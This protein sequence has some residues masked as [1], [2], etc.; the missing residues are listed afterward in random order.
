MDETDSPQTPVELLIILA[1]LADER[2]PIQ[3]I[4]PKF[5]GRFN[6][7]VDYV[8]DLAKFEQEFSDDIAVL[9]FAI[10]Q[11]GFPANL[12]LSIHSGSDKFSLYAP[13]HN[14]LK[15]SGAGVHLK[16][17]GTN[18]LEEL[19]GLAEAG[20]DGLKIAKEIYREAYS[21]RQE[22]CE[23]YAAVIDIDPAQLP[24]A[25][26]RERMV[27]RNSLC[28]LCAMI[29]NLRRTTA[30][31]GNCCTSDSKWPPKWGPAIL[32]CFARWKIASQEMSRRIYS[33]GIL[34]RCLSA[35]K[36]YTGCS[37]ISSVDVIP[38]QALACPVGLGRHDARNRMRKAVI[39]SRIRW[40]AIAHR[41]QPVHQ[42]ISIIIARP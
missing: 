26:E 34:S 20:G 19:I 33:S 12:K 39:H 22:L 7:G 41:V 15:K 21:H 32:T 25:R 29:R 24:V 40:L 13:I 16:T 5:T 30:A 35:K 36:S 8:G 4:A 9:A 14:L 6:K 2:L 18:W 31:S 10:E 42:M 27:F 37:T 17:A 28:R 23:P 1:A 11:Y 3:T 38:I